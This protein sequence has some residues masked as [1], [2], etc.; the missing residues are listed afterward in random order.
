MTKYSQNGL[1]DR[2]SGSEGHSREAVKKFMQRLPRTRQVRS[3][4][5]F[6]SR[7]V[8]FATLMIWVGGEDG[9]G[10]VSWLTGAIHRFDPAVNIIGHTIT[11][12]Y[13]IATMVLILE[14]NSGSPRADRK[15]LRR[16]QKRLK[17]FARQPFARTQM[18]ADDVCKFAVRCENHPGVLAKLTT[19]FAEKLSINLRRVESDVWVENLP[20]DPTNSPTPFGTEFCLL[21][22]EMDLPAKGDAFRAQITAAA[23]GF[24]F[25]QAKFGFDT[26]AEAMQRE[27][28]FQPCRPTGANKPFIA[29]EK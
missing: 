26:E 10:F 22:F 17:E 13:D 29:P 14:V 2:Q 24:K 8:R 11:T 1:A 3:R 7:M 12:T 28:F 19:V 4:V 16:L 5:G 23:E 25:P 21:T 6:G 15:R 27:A 9:S 20:D 18:L